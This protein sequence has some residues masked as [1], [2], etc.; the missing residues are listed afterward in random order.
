MGYDSELAYD[1]FDRKNIGIIG[2][3]VRARSLMATLRRMN[4]NVKIVALH[5]IDAPRALRDLA[6]DGEDVSE[7]RVWD[8]ADDMLDNGGLDG[9]LIATRSEEH[10]YFA[11]KV[12]ARNIPMVLEK[13]ITYLE[14]ELCELR[15]AYEKSEKKVI[16]SFPLRETPM[17]NLVKEIIDSGRIGT[18]EHIQAFNYVPYGGVYFHN[19]YCKTGPAGLFFEKS[20]HDFDWINRIAGVKPQELVVMTSQQ[21]FGGDMPDGKLCRTCERQLNCMESPFMQRNF[22]HDNPKG[23]TCAFTK[24]IKTY[25]SASVLIRYESGMHANYVENHFVRKGAGARGGRISGYSGT[26]DFDWYKKEVNVFRHHSRV[27]E[28]YRVDHDMGHFNGDESLM[29]DFVKLMHGINDTTATMEAG[30][31]STLMCMAA[32]KSIETKGFVPVIWADG[33][34]L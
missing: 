13:P 6:A 16:I 14:D 3:G 17:L 18:P 19:W 22:I 12:L 7:I 9:V 20:T 26:L 21:V 5:D 29:F 1:Y 32:R 10:V 34:H 24:E 31:V 30:F 25:D 23:D 27:S 28:T 33:K 8:D 4:M 2:C 15:E 11:K